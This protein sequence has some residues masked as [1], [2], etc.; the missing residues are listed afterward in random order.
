MRYAQ[1][2]VLSMRTDTIERV[3]KDM[4]AREEKHSA[5]VARLREKQME[6]TEELQA[7][8]S[9][10][11]DEMARMQGEGSKETR[12]STRR[13]GMSGRHQSVVPCTRPCR[14]CKR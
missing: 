6:A 12:E 10:M 5:E 11:R 2:L 8:M 13:F 4:V 7:T 14:A 1:C 3:A 9:A